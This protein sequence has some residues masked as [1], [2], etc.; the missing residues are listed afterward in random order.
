MR[1]VRNILETRPTAAEPYHT[2]TSSSSSYPRDA[3]W[4]DTAIVAIATTTGIT[5]TAARSNSPLAGIGRF[6]IFRTEAINN[7]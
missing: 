7:L 3:D 5:T 6:S 4:A 2:I 1:K